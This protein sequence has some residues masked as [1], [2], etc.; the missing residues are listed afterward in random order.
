MLSDYERRAL[1]EIESELRLM[2][3][4]RLLARVVRAAR[5]PL[6]G[7]ILVAALCLTATAVLPIGWG[8]VLVTIG[9]MA[10][11]WQL[12]R[13]ARG[14]GAFLRLHRWRTRL[15]VRVRRTRRA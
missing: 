6:A 4:E 1:R 12:C 7:A 13:I 9:A 5:A 14:T 15:A 2:H 10:L 11:G 3:K 8:E